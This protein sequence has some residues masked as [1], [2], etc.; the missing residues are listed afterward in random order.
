M[1]D[2]VK[3]WDTIQLKKWA[4]VNLMRFNNVKCKALHL[5]W[6]NPQYQYRLEDEGIENSPGEKDLGV[7]LD[8]RLDVSE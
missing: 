4:H 1:V 5:S 6:G 7:L 2:M 3:P 8:E